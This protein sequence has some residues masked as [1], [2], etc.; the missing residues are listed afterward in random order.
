MRD[1]GHVSLAYRASRLPRNKRVCV[2]RLRVKLSPRMDEYHF[3]RIKADAILIQAQCE[4]IDDSLTPVIVREAAVRILESC[5]HLSKRSL[6]PAPEI[7]APLV[8][9][10]RQSPSLTPE[11]GQDQAEKE[12]LV[13]QSRRAGEFVIPFGK[14]QGK[15]VKTLPVT[16]LCWLM[17]ARREGRNFVFKT[18]DALAW[19]RARHAVTLAQVQTYLVWRCWACGSQDMRF[20]H[21]RLCTS[22]WHDAE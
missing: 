4:V 20:K 19:T 15:Q 10:A 21:A 14:H 2:L 7:H 8:K 6:S 1:C 13:E 16:Y 12:D 5:A 17:G 22:C 11:A 3:A 9:R 18:D